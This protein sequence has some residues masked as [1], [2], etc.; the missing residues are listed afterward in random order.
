MM[1]SMCRRAVPLA[2]TSNSIR[3]VTTSSEVRAAKIHLY[4]N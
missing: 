4:A 2:R 3:R 1:R